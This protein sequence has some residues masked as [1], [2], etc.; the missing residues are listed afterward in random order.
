MT[1]WLLIS[2][3]VTL[4]WEKTFFFTT[5]ILGLTVLEHILLCIEALSFHYYGFTLNLYILLIGY[6]GLTGISNLAFMIFYVL[7]VRPNQHVKSKRDI[8]VIVFACVLNN[9]FFK[10][11]FSN[12]GN[13]EYL[14][15]NETA[16]LFS[17]RYRCI[18]I[19]YQ[20]LI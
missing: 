5:C 14:A 6:L 1:L 11:L 9:R 12:I 3:F 17:S 20:T 13:K 2:T 7:L 4:N 16:E 18:K 19:T 8:I 15:L 10:V